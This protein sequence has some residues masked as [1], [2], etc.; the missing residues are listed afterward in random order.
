MAISFLKS[1]IAKLRTNQA[2]SDRECNQAQSVKCFSD[3]QQQEEAF[4]AVDRGCSSVPV[5]QIVGSVGRYQ[6]FDSQFKIKSHLPPERFQNIKA[7]MRVGKVMPPVKLYQIKDE[8][9]VLDGN[10]RVAAA[11]ELGHDEIRADIL[12]FVPSKNTFE[13]ILY[14]EM[15]AFKTATG[16]TNPIEL[17]EVGQYIHLQNQISQHH[18]YLKQH[19]E[20]DVAYQ[21]AAKDW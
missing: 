13:N 7:A 4:D 3:D 2:G 9:Y 12:E 18:R 6:D 21:D 16:L 14:R 20:T 19:Q 15:S 10:H 5:T 11:K 17:T 1:I 8:Y